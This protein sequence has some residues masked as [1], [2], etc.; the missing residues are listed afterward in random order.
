VF[1]DVADDVAAARLAKRQLDRF[2]RAGAAFHRR[3]VEGFRAL[4]TADPERWIVARPEGAKEDV[5]AG[6][7]DAVL[8]RLGDVSAR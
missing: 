4:A 1:L 7:H 5:A 6:V 3:V 2:E 8:A